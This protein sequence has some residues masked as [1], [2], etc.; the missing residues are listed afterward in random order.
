MRLFPLHAIGP[1]QESELSVGSGSYVS[2]F[3]VSLTGLTAYV[4]E[5]HCK[6]FKCINNSYIRKVYYIIIYNY[7]QLYYLCIYLMTR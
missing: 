3:I 7:E 1:G 5:M 2:E 6:T 4:L